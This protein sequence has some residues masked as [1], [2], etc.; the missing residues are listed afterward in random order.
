MQK[1]LGSE[2]LFRYVL[3]QQVASKQNRYLLL[4]TPYMSPVIR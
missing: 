1:N 4:A 2:A 3:T